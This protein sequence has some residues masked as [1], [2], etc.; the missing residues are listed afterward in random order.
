MGNWI[1]Y[2]EESKRTIFEEPKRTIL[3]PPRFRGNELNGNERFLN[4]AFQ[5]ILGENVSPLYDLT[6]IHVGKGIGI[7]FDLSS[8]ADDNRSKVGVSGHIRPKQIDGSKDHVR[9]IGFSTEITDQEKC[10]NMFLKGKATPKMKTVCTGILHRSGFGAF[11]GLGLIDTYEPAVG[12]CMNL[13]EAYG[14]ITVSKTQQRGSLVFGTESRILVG[15]DA[16]VDLSKSKL[17]DWN[18][19]I[20]TRGFGGT[21]RDYVEI[22]WLK[23]GTRLVGGYFQQFQVLR[24]CYNPLEALDV[25]GVVSFLDVGILY[26]RDPFVEDTLA[27][28]ASFQVNKNM[29]LKGVL[30]TNGPRLAVAFK[31]SRLSPQTTVVLAGDARGNYGI[32]L[33]F[34]SSDSATYEK[35]RA[36]QTLDQQRHQNMRIDANRYWGLS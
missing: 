1:V 24:E 23:G 5:A 15:M 7:Q 3:L 27:A 35:L 21:I 32:E 13:P 22:K 2:E 17:V 30:D 26:E 19:A 33:E 25:S 31:S 9:D 20:R 12:I 6:D 16:T 34:S 29:L 18:A 4:G 28:A 36:N 8:A 11:A 14:E 10:M